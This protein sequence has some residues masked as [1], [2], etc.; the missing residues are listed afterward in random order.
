MVST[1]RKFQPHHIQRL[2]IDSTGAYTEMCEIGRL[3]ETD[4][5]PYH[6]N[7]AKHRHPY[8]AIYD[9]LFAPLRHKQIHFA[10]IGIAAGNSVILWWNYFRKAAEA[11]TLYF[12]DRCPDT[13]E[14]VKQLQFPVEPYTALMDVGVDGDIARALKGGIGDGQYD[15]I[16]D[17]SSHDYNHII[18]MIHEAIPFVRSGGYLIVEDVMR[19]WS[20]DEIEAAIQD[21]LPQCALAYF[22]ICNHEERYSPGWNNDKMLVLVKA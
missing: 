20:E 12:F 19:T 16:L 10:E 9:M 18:R 5:S 15:V 11:R 21:I 3:A 14:T 22:V 17:D 6:Q 4:K 1:D 13:I 2:V 8:T 7:P